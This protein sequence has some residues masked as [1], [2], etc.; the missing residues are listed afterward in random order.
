MLTIGFVAGCFAGPRPSDLRA[1]EFQIHGHSFVTI[2]DDIA[3]EKKIVRAKELATLKMIAIAW[4]INRT[5]QSGQDGNTSELV[6]NADDC[7]ISDIKQINDRSFEFR[8]DQRIARRINLPK[9]LEIEPG[10][11][12]SI[13]IGR[14]TNEQ[15]A[16]ILVNKEWFRQEPFYSWDDPEKVPTGQKETLFLTITQE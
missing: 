4:F 7:L 10:E 16:D 13:E 11:E 12:F 2:E 8:F 14:A 5:I 1:N 6:A 3:E 9:I 15:M